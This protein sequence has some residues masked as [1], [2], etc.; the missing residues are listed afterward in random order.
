MLF[1]LDDVGVWVCF[2]RISTL[3]DRR[4]R[5]I[6]VGSRF[7]GK[8]RIFRRGVAI[9][10]NTGE[11]VCDREK[12]KGA[13]KRVGGG[14]LTVVAVESEISGRTGKAEPD[15]LVATEIIRL[16]LQHVGA[17]GLGQREGGA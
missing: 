12:L 4:W 5:D 14:R 3:C 17:V 7:L 11:G 15:R 13:S 8:V 6:R 16:S 1:E 9:L 10:A 2:V